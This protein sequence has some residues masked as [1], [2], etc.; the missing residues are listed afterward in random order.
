MLLQ[1]LEKNRESILA[2]WINQ[3]ISTYEPEMVNFLKKEKN[4]FANPVRNTIVTSI[5]LIYDGFLKSIAIDEFYPKLEEIIKLRAVQDFSPSNSLS[6]LF[7]LKK[8]V[9]DE[10]ENSDQNKDLSK[11]IFEFDQKVDALIRL[12]FDIYTKCRTKIYEIRIKEIKSQSQRAFE[13]F[14]RKEN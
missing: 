3:T 14:E 9:L 5:E 4:Q 7:G 6:F 1:F 12:A 13:I 2:K 10:V 11:E 8:I